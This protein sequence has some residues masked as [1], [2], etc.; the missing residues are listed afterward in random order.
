MVHL[1]CPLR[2]GQTYSAPVPKSR[3][4]LL[5]AQ[6][7]P[8]S[9]PSVTPA[10]VWNV[11]LQSSLA[12]GRRV[13]RVAETSPLRKSPGHRSQG[14]T[15]EWIPTSPQYPAILQRGQ[16]GG[17]KQMDTFLKKHR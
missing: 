2:T 4:G 17:E 7:T 11:L 13:P 1:H 3:E 10:R 8:V 12:G 9:Q 15:L 14:L 5:L 16:V 6:L